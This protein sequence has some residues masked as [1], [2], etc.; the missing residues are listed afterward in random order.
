MSQQSG[1]GRAVTRVEFALSDGSYPFVSVS[2][3]ESCSVILEK[4]LPKTDD[5]YA[6]FFSV[7]DTRPDRLVE[8]IEDNNGGEA[9]VLERT[10]DGGLVEIDVQDNCPVVSLADLGAVP[11]TARS[12]DG[13][14]TIVADVPDQT[15]TAAVIDSFLTAHPEAE[16]AAKKQR[17][18][19]VPLFGFKNY[20]S[21]SESLT[22]RQREV[23]STAHEAGYYNWPR[24]ATAADLAALLDISE[25]TLHKHL[26]AAE[27]KLVATMFACPHDERAADSDN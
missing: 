11:Q 13:Q 24:G 23:L 22:D 1:N 16:L 20:A 26:R 17:E 8:R 9:R 21:N 14:G 15:K 27:Q 4:C 3:A 12:V 6:E 5:T 10:S 2:A 18:S 19:I 7:T 25:P